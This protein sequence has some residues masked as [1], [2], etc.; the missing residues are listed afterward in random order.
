MASLVTQAQ[1]W[2]T[3]VFNQTYASV[4][5]GY[6]VVH[7]DV[8]NLFAGRSVEN[9]NSSAA[10]KKSDIALKVALVALASLVFPTI[11]MVILAFLTFARLT[12]DHNPG[13]NGLLNAVRG[14]NAEQPRSFF[15]LF[16]D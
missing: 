14:A 2:A 15:G 4:A 16:R 13:I 9:F 1:N 12:S 7:N 11:P 6:E 5:A 8:T 10:D 3:G